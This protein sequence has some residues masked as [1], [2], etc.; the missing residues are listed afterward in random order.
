MKTTLTDN[1]FWALVQKMD[2]KNRSYEVIGEL[3]VDGK[4]ICDIN[5]A[6]LLLEK[7]KEK[8]SEL[9]RKAFNMSEEDYYEYINLGDDGLSDLLSNIV[10]LGK[11]AFESIKEPQDFADYEARESFAYS[12]HP[13]YDLLDD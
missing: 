7:Y 6:K 12:F 11:K 8:Y 4:S 1:E 2:W 3:L 13:L 9:E 10:G 5:T